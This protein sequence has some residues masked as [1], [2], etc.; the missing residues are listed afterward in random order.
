MRSIFV[1]L[2]LVSSVLISQAQS[3]KDIKGNYDA[4]SDIVAMITGFNPEGF[5]P[6]MQIT[7][8]FAFEELEKH[9]SSPKTSEQI[10]DTFAF[11]ELEKKL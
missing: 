8:T 2:I 10:A 3:I 7:D 6:Q 1:F 4:E 5:E 9:F 11:S